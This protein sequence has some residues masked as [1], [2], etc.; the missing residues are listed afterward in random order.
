MANPFSEIQRTFL[1]PVNTHLTNVLDK[2]SGEIAP[3]LTAMATLYICWEGLLILLGRSQQPLNDVIGKAVRL[4]AILAVL[5]SAA[6][7]KE[8]V[9]DVA[10]NG[11]ADGLSAVVMGVGL[12]KGGEVSQFDQALKSLEE[13]SRRIWEGSSWVSPADWVK[14]AVNNMLLLVAGY[15]W[16]GSAFVTVM[17]LKVM[18]YLVVLVGPLFIAA[19]M[20]ETTK[21][22]FQNWLGA[23]VYLIIYQILVSAVVGFSF[24]ALKSLIATFNPMFIYDI[25]ITALCS[26]ITESFVTGRFGSSMRAAMSL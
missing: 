14:C 22:F 15:F 4:A 18:M 23:V 10:V 5:L 1:E 20:F 9:V 11:I 16:L 2:L 13:A 8:Y 25:V 24:S 12:P 19:L 17:F 6:T 3:T 21:P 26:T 7:Y